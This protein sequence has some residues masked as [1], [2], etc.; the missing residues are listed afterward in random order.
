MKYVD[1]F[2]QDWRIRKG[3]RYLPRNARVI[4]VGAHQG[5]LFR[6]LGPGLRA[7]FGIEPLLRAPWE[8][9]RFAIFP[10]HFPAVRPKDNEW[11][12]I[13]MLAV[14]EHIP[15]SEQT[16]LA[17]ACYDLL[18]VGGRVIITVPSSAV[19]YILSTLRFMRAI[20]G[21]SLEEHFGFQP[22]ETVRIFA[23]PRFK[24]VR[25]ERFELA[26]NHLF[27]FEKNAEP[28]RLSDLEAGVP[29]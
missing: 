26:L 20:D 23:L 17:E 4:D 16:A 9:S 25:H 27:V 3:V 5:E 24:L 18:R 11:D 19:D 12:A 28:S 21:M 15:R 1:R 2:L 14:L 10:G 8:T 22:A 6:A 13:T 29:S 7:G